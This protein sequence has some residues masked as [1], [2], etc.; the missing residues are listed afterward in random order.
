[1]TETALYPVAEV[2]GLYRTI[3]ELRQQVASADLIRADAMERMARSEVLDHADRA[4][5]AWTAWKRL[6][7]LVLPGLDQA[8]SQTRSRYGQGREMLS[9]VLSME[10]MVRM[11]RME[12]AIE[13]MRIAGGKEEFQKAFD[14]AKDLL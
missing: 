9:M 6:D 7:S 10:E 1:M 2:R 4:R 3:A 14:D 13:R 8:L 11:T 5:G 12:A